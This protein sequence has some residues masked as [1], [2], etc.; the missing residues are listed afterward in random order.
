MIDRILVRRPISVGILDLTEED[1]HNSLEPTEVEY[2]AI[3]LLQKS[4]VLEEQIKRFKAL[5]IDNEREFTEVVETHDEIVGDYNDLH[6]KYEKLQTT[7]SDLETYILHKEAYFANLEAS[8]SISFLDAANA[9]AKVDAS[10]TEETIDVQIVDEPILSTPALD[11]AGSSTGNRGSCGYK[12]DATSSKYYNV[13]F[14]AG[15]WRAR[16]SN[17][18]IKTNL[19]CTFTNETEAALAVDAYLD[20]VKDTR[21]IRNRD[22]HA[23]VMEAYL[24]QQEMDKLLD[25]QAQ[26]QEQKQCQ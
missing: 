25:A 9:L 10:S 2:V 23:E 12:G 4:K 3:R 5:C 6:E 20:K 11:I 26:A 14:H 17:N 7:L 13:D 21:R 18:G 24:L 19:G 16:V 8:G 22:K 1:I 15:K